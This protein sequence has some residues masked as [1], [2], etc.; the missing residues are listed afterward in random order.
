MIFTGVLYR[1]P[2]IKSIKNYRTRSSVAATN[3]MYL[4]KIHRDTD[5]EIFIDWHKFFHKD[6]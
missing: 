4:N 3:L 6:I 5:R 1:K 2:I